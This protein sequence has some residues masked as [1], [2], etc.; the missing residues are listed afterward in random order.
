MLKK[1]NV[2]IKN[3]LAFYIRLLISWQSLYGIRLVILKI[4]NEVIK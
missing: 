4:K 2:F 3:I 1:N